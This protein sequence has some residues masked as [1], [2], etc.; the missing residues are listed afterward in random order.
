MNLCFV[1]VGNLFFVLLVSFEGLSPATIAKI[2]GIHKLVGL[3]EYGF[4]AVARDSIHSLPECKGATKFGPTFET[5]CGRLLVRT[6][7][8]SYIGSRWVNFDVYL[9][10]LN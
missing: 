4:A 9:L 2:G 6:F 3:N 5:P 8:E 7:S 10:I 1:H